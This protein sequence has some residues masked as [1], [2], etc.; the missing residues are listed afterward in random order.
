M[1]PTV[2]IH[3]APRLLDWPDALAGFLP[4]PLTLV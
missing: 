4:D 3:H 2:A 1:A